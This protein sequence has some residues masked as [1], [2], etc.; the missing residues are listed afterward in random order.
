MRISLLALAGAV[1][2]M[3]F[4]VSAMA[5]THPAASAPPNPLLLNMKSFEADSFQVPLSTD[6]ALQP[7]EIATYIN[8][9]LDKKS[10]YASPADGVIHLSCHGVECYVIH[11]TLTVGPSGPVAWETNVTTG[12]GWL[13]CYKSTILP[14]YQKDE[15]T[16]AKEIVRKLE[17]ARSP[18]PR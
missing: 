1:L 18:Q 9:T 12:K 17:A 7:T 13:P 16:V 6:H 10:D 11:A 15:R 5:D 4:G 14:C 3:A 2:F 8:R